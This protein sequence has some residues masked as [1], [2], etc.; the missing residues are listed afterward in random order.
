[1]TLLVAIR[2]AAVRSWGLSLASIL[3]GFTVGRSV[4]EVFASAS[5]WKWAILAVV[6]FSFG[7]LIGLNVRR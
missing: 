1:M 7:A 2:P 4:P 3:H 6:G 5:S